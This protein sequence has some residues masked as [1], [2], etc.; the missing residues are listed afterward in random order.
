MLK[1]CVPASTIGPESVRRT[2]SMLL[3]SQVALSAPLGI[4]NA[5]ADCNTV[6]PIL[7][8]NLVWQFIKTIPLSMNSNLPLEECLVF[9]CKRKGVLL[10][11]LS[12]N[13]WFDLLRGWRAIIGGNVFELR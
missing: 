1:Q 10:G 5:K 3:E 13:R 12:L 4:P 6:G 8:Q 2:P 11:P 7:K 9:N